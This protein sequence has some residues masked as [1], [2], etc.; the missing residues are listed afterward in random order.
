MLL[1]TSHLYEKQ[2][3]Y[4]ALTLMACLAHGDSK[5]PLY[6]L[7]VCIGRRI[8]AGKFYRVLITPEI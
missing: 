4:I 5:M 2:I 1:L 6:D 3:I 7:F 8:W